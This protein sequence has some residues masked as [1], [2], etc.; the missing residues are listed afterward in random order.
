MFYFGS[1]KKAVTILGS[2]VS[3]DIFEYL[4]SD[5]LEIEQYFARTKIVSQLSAPMNVQEDEINLQSKFQRH[6]VLN[7]LNKQQFHII[8]RNREHYCVIDFIDERF[9]L[10]KISGTYITKSNELINSGWLAG[11]EYTEEQYRLEDHE[12]RIADE[13][14]EE[15]LKN[16]LDGLLDL[17][18]PNRII[19]HKAYMVDC[20]ID[21]DGERKMF[22]KP[23]LNSNQKNNELLKFLYKYTEHY[24]KKAK[25]IDLCHKYDADE[26]HKWGLSPMHY[27][28]EY[29]VEAAK[30]IKEYIKL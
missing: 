3:R 26:K 20:F 6:Q 30:L 13:R 25:S 28:E 29:Y 2:C 4:D 12:W 7:D 24:L 10:I 16:Y 19:I 9:Q 18:R 15:Y 21:K 11:K 14:L 1:K 5:K 8:G 27:Q 22:N 23:Y 17:F